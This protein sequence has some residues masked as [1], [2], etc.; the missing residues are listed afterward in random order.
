MDCV[1]I[2]AIL[3]K[4]SYKQKL[5]LMPK[6]LLFLSLLFCSISI[7]KGFAQLSISAYT[8]HADTKLGIGY[9]FNEKLWSEFRVYMGT[10][11][12]KVTP[13][14]TLNYNFVRRENYDT[15]I[16]IGGVLNHIKGVVLPVGVGI[17]P[18]KSL[19][20]FALHIEF[21]PLYEL[22]YGDLYLRG[23]VGIRYKFKKA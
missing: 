13:E 3:T 22:D 15:Y 11:I 2:C 4:I 7:P 12:S 19:K 6:K 23:F 16:G 10:N 8:N 5:I 1:L 20:N 21:T 14:I 17:K 9:Q 18:F